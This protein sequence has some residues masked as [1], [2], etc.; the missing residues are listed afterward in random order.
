MSPS[1]TE[2]PPHALLPAEDMPV[3]EEL[4]CG[5]YE[6]NED[7]IIAFATHWDPQYFH[8]D[9][10]AAAH[11]NYGGLIASGLHTTSIYQRLA[12]T[13]LYDR[14]DIIA[15]KEIRSLR[16]L[17]P[18][19]AGDV[20]TCSVLVRSVEPD[21]AGRCVVHLR[22]RLSNQRGAPVL[23]LELESLVRSRRS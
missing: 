20:L 22:G 17:R 10:Q 18:V 1:G 16:F 23:E 12:V 13:G 14:Y 8:I 15:G 7:E 21:G 2:P 6:V 3:G 4:D 5:S 9:P 19:R 11:S